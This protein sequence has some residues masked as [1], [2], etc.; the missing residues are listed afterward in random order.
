MKK[1]VFR[2][3]EYIGRKGAVNVYNSASLHYTYQPEEPVMLSE[4]VE[5]KK[6]H[7]VK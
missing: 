7:S 5:K 6:K 4:F 2:L 3:L 1:M